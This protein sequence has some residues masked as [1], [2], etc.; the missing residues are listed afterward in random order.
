M[1]MCLFLF[2]QFKTQRAAEFCNS[3]QFVDALRHKVGG[4]GFDSRQGPWKFKATYSCCP[5]LASLGPLDR[6]QECV[7]RN[8]LGRKVRPEHGADKSGVLTSCNFIIPLCAFQNKGLKSRQHSYIVYRIY[9]QHVSATMRRH[10][11]KI[12]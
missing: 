4:S 7:P 10:Q 9:L 3:T 8:F 6:K 1:V 2:V 12:I 11:A 5:H